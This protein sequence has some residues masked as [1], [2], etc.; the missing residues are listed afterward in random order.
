MGTNLTPKETIL[1]ERPTRFS[2]ACNHSIA[3]M[4]AR[5][6]LLMAA[7]QSLLLGSISRLVYP[8]LAL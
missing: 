4:E 7:P 3:A 1:Q 5:G 8:K 6:I 2:H